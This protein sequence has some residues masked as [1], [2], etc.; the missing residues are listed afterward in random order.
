MFKLKRCLSTALILCMCLSFSAPAVSLSREEKK[1][2][3]TILSRI[4]A[5]GG[6]RD[7][8]SVAD[9]GRIDTGRIEAYVDEV[10][11]RYYRT[12]TCSYT[13]EWAGGVWF[14]GFTV[15][16]SEAN[17]MYIYNSLLVKKAKAIVKKSTRRKMSKT[18]KAKAL[19]KAV[20]KKLSYRDYNPNR[21]EASLANNLKKNKGVCCTYAQLYQAC[22]D[23]AKIPCQHVVGYADGGLHSWN[24][25]R[26]KGKWRYVDVTWYDCTKQSRYILRKKQW[27]SHRATRYCTVFD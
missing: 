16:T 25:V 21:W 7:Y 10:C 22:C 27:R 1:V 3:D 11:G 2:A 24:R 9:S 23:I 6:F 17:S 8:V 20:A 13:P 5:G 19:A 15:Y 4:R 26:L 12:T 14:D 18:A